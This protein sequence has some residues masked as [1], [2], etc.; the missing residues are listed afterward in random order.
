[1]WPVLLQGSFPV[2]ILWT[3]LIVLLGQ[4]CGPCTPTIG[5]NYTA[6]CM[7]VPVVVAGRFTVK[8]VA[9]SKMSVYSSTQPKQTCPPPTHT[10]LRPCTQCW[11]LSILTMKSDW[12]IASS[13][14]GPIGPCIIAPNACSSHQRA[15]HWSF[16][17]CHRGGARHGWGRGWGIVTLCKCQAVLNLLCVRTCTGNMVE[18]GGGVLIMWAGKIPW[19]CKEL[20][21]TQ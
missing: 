12:Q 14:N 7:T 1:M 18:W 15:P 3:S 13:L 6:V 10:H 16:G 11:M 19:W 2:Q 20:E 4:V 8:L 9:H 5:L 21:R 17:H